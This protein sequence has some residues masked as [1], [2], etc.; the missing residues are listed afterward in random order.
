LLRDG[1][2]VTDEYFKNSVPS[3]CNKNVKII[4]GFNAGQSFTIVKDEL[5][6]FN[7]APDDHSAFTGTLTRYNKYTFAQIGNVIT[8]NLAHCNAVDYNAKNDCLLIANGS[9]D[10]TLKPSIYIF[11]N[12]SNWV[13]LT[14]ADFNTID[15]V[16]IN[17]YDALRA[18]ISLPKANACWGEDNNGKNNIIYL[19]GNNQKK[20]FKIILGMGL[21]NLSVVPTPDTLI[22]WGSFLSGKSDTQYNGTAKIIKTFTSTVDFGSN[23]GIIFYDGGLLSSIGFTNVQAVHLQLLNNNSIRCDKAYT[24]QIL[25]DSGNNI[26][27]EAEGVTILDGLYLLQGYRG[28]LEGLSIT[29]LSNRQGGKGVTGTPINFYFKCIQYRIF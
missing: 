3:T 17:F 6:V 20:I 10:A 21:N 27:V 11:P 15:K 14:Q 23:Q 26:D 12:V 28:A 13:N 1:D 16:V 5:W 19:S 24:T 22:N 18:D 8:H 4:N 29:P 9:G 2:L 25:D 7:E